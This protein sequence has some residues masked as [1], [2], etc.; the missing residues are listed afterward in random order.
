[1][2]GRWRSEYYSASHDTLSDAAIVDPIRVVLVGDHSYLEAWCRTAEAV[3]LFRFDRIVDAQVLD[4]PSA[5]PRA[6]GAG[7]PRH[8]AVRRRPGRCRR[9]RCCIDRSA[10]WMFDYYPLRGGHASCPTVR[11]RRR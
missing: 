10:S 3:R 9:R 2:A 5:P 8:L 1:M 4:E 11:A 7:R 6:R